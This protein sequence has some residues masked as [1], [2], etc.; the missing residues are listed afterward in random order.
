MPNAGPGAGN[1]QTRAQNERAPLPPAGPMWFSTVM[2][3]GILST[4]LAREVG[5][6]SALL[7]PA[8]ALLVIGLVALV[9]LSAAFAVR[10][11]RDRAALTSTLTNPAI[12]P[13][14]GT[15]SMGILAVGSAALT[16]GPHLGALAHPLLVL[17]VVLWLVGTALG[18]VTTFG[19]AAVLLRRRGGTPA[20]AW[21]L[22]VVPPMVSATTGAA[23]VPSAPAGGVRDLL[24]VVSTACFLIS[25]SIGAAVFAVGYH[26]CARRVPLPIPASVSAWIPLGVVGQSMAAAQSLATQSGT[27]L[28][29]GT[30]RGVHHVANGYG[31]AMLI[32]AV[33]VVGWAIAMTVR[34]FRA[35]MAFAPGWWAL[36]FPIGT[37]AL[38][39]RLLGASTGVQAI[40]TV[41]IVCIVVLAGT[42]T[43]CTVNTA[44]ALRRAVA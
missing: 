32:C 39:T 21:G 36:T 9:G 29:P 6:V 11:G 28:S 33:P 40:A 7:V 10:I 41:G 1:A 25:L 27:V 26:H 2:G 5:N 44:W 31:Y 18:L 23:L 12:S 43:F 15:V 35:R 3:T 34:G 17:D 24:L 4:L 22:A 16:A 30:T 20:L 14:W 38:G 8:T 13:T 42:W 37:L 19:F